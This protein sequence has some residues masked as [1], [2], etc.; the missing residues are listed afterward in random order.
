MIWSRP[1]RTARL[2]RKGRSGSRD[3]TT[4]SRMG[5]SASSASTSD[6]AWRLLLDPPLKG[7]WNMA[8]DEVLL[9]GVAARSAPP[10][11]R[12]YSWTPACLS[13]GSFPPF[14]PRAAAA[15]AQACG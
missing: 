12:F 10:T 8:V 9:D 2:G 11:L 3:A 1:D 5:M 7:A 6:A 15:W 4:S 13:L 14:G